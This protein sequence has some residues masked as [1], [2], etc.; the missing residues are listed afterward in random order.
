MRPPKPG[1]R[2]TASEPPAALAHLRDERVWHPWDYTWNDKKKAWDKPPLSSKT[3]RPA[4]GTFRAPGFLATF[5]EAIETMRRHGL[6]GIGLSLEHARLSGADLDH[7]V[8]DS[9]SYTALAARVLALAETYA[10]LSPSGEGIHILAKAADAPVIKRDDLGIELYSRGRYFTL[11]GNRVE[12]A[13]DEIREAPALIA[14]LQ[15]IDADNP[16]PGKEKPARPPDRA[17]P[18][19]GADFFGGVN[20]AALARLDAWVPSLHPAARRQATGAWRITAEDLGRN[21]Q[22]DISYHPDGIQDFGEEHGVTAIDAVMRYGSATNAKDAA[23]WLCHRMGIEPTAL[24]WEATGAKPMPNGVH[25]KRADRVVAKAEK[26]PAKKIELIA[27]N[28]IKLLD[29]PQYRVERILPFTGLAIIWGPPKSGKSFWLFDLLMHVALGWDYRG[30]EVEQGPVVYCYFEGQR[31]ASRR[32]EA[33][34]QR[35]LKN[36]GGDVPFYLMPVT[37]NL[38][39]DHGALI[40][41]IKALGIKPVAVALDT[42]NRSLQGS[43]SKDEDM[44]RYIAACD[45]I[46]D[47]FDCVVP[48]VHHCGHDATRPRG[49][50]SLGGAHDAMIAVKRAE[51]GDAVI[52]EVEEMKDGDAGVRLASRLEVV[53]VG[54]DRRGQ[55][56]TSCVVVPSEAPVQ[57]AEKKGRGR[58]KGSPKEMIGLQVLELALA[59]VGARP[60]A[61]NHIPQGAN[62]RVVTLD[63]YE[64]YAAKSLLHNPD[65]RRSHQRQALKQVLAGLAAKNQ[66]RTWD[67]YIWKI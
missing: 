24:G 53:E 55:P 50:S 17:A 3:G 30:Y 66:V 63:Q 35:H 26:P 23:M 37:L 49:H 45:A 33:F 58:P 38:V 41:A 15:K 27:F 64:R 6:A 22:E 60:P 42:L 28:D 21:L 62:V 2:F 4:T 18:T 65:A 25:E 47:S 54:T 52:A 36:Y 9:G 19:R 20:S 61:S 57:Q 1:Y 16:K 67:D 7:C 48:L 5:D 8:T 46:R 34:R 32:K 44:A 10:E 51:D 59:E 12:D 31:A 43:E 29:D 39:Q 40:E 56:L 13:P 14:L 11:T